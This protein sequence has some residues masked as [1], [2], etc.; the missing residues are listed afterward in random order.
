MIC[1]AGGRVR[2]Q[3]L[4]ERRRVYRW[5]GF[6]HMQ[7]L[8]GLEWVTVLDGRGRV[9]VA[10]LPA[11]RHVLRVGAE[12][13]CGGGCVLLRLRCRLQRWHVRC[14]RGRVRVEAVPERR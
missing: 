7:L 9:C 5:R 13:E 3:S 12:L 4:S 6:V 11:Q 10:A 8:G 1:S 14:E 2:E